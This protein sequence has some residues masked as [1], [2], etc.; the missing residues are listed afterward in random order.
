MYIALLQRYTLVHFPLTGGVVAKMALAWRRGP[1]NYDMYVTILPQLSE[2]VDFEMIYKQ[3][4]LYAP[5]K[6]I[7]SNFNFSNLHASVTA[8]AV[9]KFGGVRRAASVRRRCFSF[10]F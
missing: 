8:R 10:Y 2:C 1:M 7:K 9:V 4:D 3:E 5:W 6:I